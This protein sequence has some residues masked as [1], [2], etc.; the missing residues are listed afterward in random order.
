MR[1]TKSFPPLPRQ[2]YHRVAVSPLFIYF[3]IRSWAI[4]FRQGF[5][6]GYRLSNEPRNNGMARRFSPTVGLSE[7]PKRSVTG[8]SEGKKERM[9]QVQ[10]WPQL[11]DRI[12]E[13]P[14]CCSVVIF[15]S[16]PPDIGPTRSRL[17]KSVYPQSIAHRRDQPLSIS[18]AHFHNQPPRFSFV[19]FLLSL[20]LISCSFDFHP[21]TFRCFLQKLLLYVRETFHRFTFPFLLF[22]NVLECSRMLRDRKESHVGTTRRKLQRDPIEN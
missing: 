8:V 6:P 12:L 5:I 7:K 2:P 15:F 17:I 18:L 9:R 22:A 10:R 14:W 4:F 16:Q 3:F 19:S 1:S 13:H 11:I 20:S 21:E